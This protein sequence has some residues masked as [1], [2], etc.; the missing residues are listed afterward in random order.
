MAATNLAWIDLETTGLD[1]HLDPILE[2]GLIITRARPPFETVATYEAVI[3]PDEDEWY[4]RM[5]SFVREMHTGN[6]LLNDIESHGRALSDV[7]EEVV[8]LF[9]EYGRPHNYMLAG[10]GVSHFDHRFINAQMPILAKWLQYPSLDVGV[11]RRAL[12]FSG[13]SDLDAFGQ[14]FA[15]VNDKPH[16]GLDD[17]ADHLNEFRAYSKMFEGIPQDV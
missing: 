12:G 4:T 1:A 14:T 2:I 6:N 5:N 3:A 17:V 8:S 10:S 16:R 11:I 13:R 9:K 15:T 7:E